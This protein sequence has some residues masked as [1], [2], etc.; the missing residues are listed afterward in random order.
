MKLVKTN[1]THTVN[2]SSSWIVYITRT[3][4]EANALHKFAMTQQELLI[5]ASGDWYY[6]VSTVKIEKDCRVPE[7]FHERGYYAT[8]IEHNNGDWNATPKYDLY[9]AE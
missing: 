4:E 5:G 2:K 9:I 6:S 8:V 1:F 7:F 3:R